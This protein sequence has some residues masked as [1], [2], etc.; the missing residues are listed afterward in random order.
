MLFTRYSALK[1]QGRPLYEY[2]R[3]GIPLPEPIKARKCTVS[4]L[5][6]VGW[7]DGVDQTKYAWPTKE[8]E[9][10]KREMIDE[11]KKLMKGAKVEVVED[12]KSAPTTKA[13][14]GEGE[15]SGA[16]VEPPTPIVLDFTTGLDAPAET[17]DLAEEGTPPT[18]ELKMTV[19]SGT[20]VRSIAHDL[21]HAL[22]SAAHV[23]TLTRTRQGEFKLDDEDGCV[24]WSVFEDALQEEEKG[25]LV[26]HV[27]GEDG[28]LLLREWEQRV[29]KCWRDDANV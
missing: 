15:G 24:P 12:G 7:T 22:G 20:Y 18:F 3:E 6:V 9:K 2:A 21:G 16:Q 1:M 25:A 5:E 8:L 13:K 28:E 14:E 4:S 17:P 27:R 23:V 11:V 10:D 26:E 29:L 19:S